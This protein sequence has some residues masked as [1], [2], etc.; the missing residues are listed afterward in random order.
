MTV[1]HNP[2][3]ARLT[4]ERL[5]KIMRTLAS[6]AGDN[7]IDELKARIAAQETRVRALEAALRLAEE[8]AA[9]IL[10][11]LEAAGFKVLGRES[12]EEKVAAAIRRGG[13][14]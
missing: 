4:A 10:A 9:R 7:H 6:V 3:P 14:S 12:T 5:G 2:T 11:A 8:V 13:A 1:N